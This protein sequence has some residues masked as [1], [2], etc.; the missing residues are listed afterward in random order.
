MFNQLQ[1]LLVGDVA[2][3]S[4]NADSNVCPLNGRRIIRFKV[5]VMKESFLPPIRLQFA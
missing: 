5:V 3:F 4:D 2:E 1:A